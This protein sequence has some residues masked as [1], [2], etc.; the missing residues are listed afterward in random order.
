MSSQQQIDANRQNAQ[1]STGPT[2]EAGRKRSSLN[3]TKHGMT[4]QTLILSPEEKE[5]YEA[6][7]KSYFE[8][9]KPYDAVTKQ[10][11]QQLADALWSVNQIF[12]QQS[13]LIALINAATAEL[14]EAGDALAAA[15]TLAPLSKTLHTYTIYE[16]RR[17]R[18]ADAL[19]QKL[20]ALLQAYAE[21]VHEE[22][23]LAAKVANQHKAQGKP[24]D[25]A[26]YGFV[27]SN[28]QIEQFLLGQELAKQDET[29]PKQPA[30]PDIDALKAEVARIIAAEQAAEKKK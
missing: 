4:G 30:V 24:F 13:N 5:S 26:A 25:P 16:T 9:Y 18:T 3:A 21:Q 2:S 28:Q 23:P 29:G 11:T 27:C 14:N 22:L 20:E 1:K 6:H 12:V 15:T 17:R 8:K 10:L 7:V 19:E